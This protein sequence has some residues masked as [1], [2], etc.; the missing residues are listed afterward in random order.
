MTIPDEEMVITA[1]KVLRIKEPTVSR[2]KVLKQL[3]E[4]NNWV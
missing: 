3:K 2:A 1:V 4:E